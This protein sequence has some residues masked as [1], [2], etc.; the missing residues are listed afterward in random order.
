MSGRSKLSG[1]RGGGEHH[2]ALA[3]C[4]RLPGRRGQD[5]ASRGASYG[6]KEAKGGQPARLGLW[7]KGRERKDWHGRGDPGL[8]DV[9]RRGCVRVFGVRVNHAPARGRDL[10]GSECGLTGSRAGA[11]TGGREGEGEREIKGSE[12]CGFLCV[13]VSQALWLSTGAAWH[14]QECG[15]SRLPRPPPVPQGGGRQEKGGKRG[16][17]PPNPTRASNKRPIY[18]IFYRRAQEAG[19]AP[20]NRTGPAACPGP[21][22]LCEV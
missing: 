19:R 10:G 9:P 17:N 22:G 12:V 11:P 13:C 4:G 21:P 2:Q 18:L 5:A 15:F 14:P 7:D 6:I 3:R 1:A 8:A 16:R 20:R